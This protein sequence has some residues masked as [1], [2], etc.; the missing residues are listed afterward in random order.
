VRHISAD[1]PLACSRSSNR[2]WRW[3]KGRVLHGNHRTFFY[4]TFTGGDTSDSIIGVV[5][6][7]CRGDHRVLLE[8]PVRPHWSQARSLVLPRGYD[9]FNNTVRTLSF[10]LDSNLQVPAPPLARLFNCT[11]HSLAQRSRCLHGALK[12]NT[13][14]VRSAIVELTDKSNVARGFSL[15]QMA[16]SVGYVIGLG[17]LSTVLCLR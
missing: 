4:H 17:T 16:W 7:C 11:I 8:S 13:G 12:G 1:L 6:L 9:C 10:F 3:A 2:G 15:L 5:A 14:V